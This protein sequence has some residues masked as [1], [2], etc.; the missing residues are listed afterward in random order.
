MKKK[1]LQPPKNGRIEFT[2]PIQ[3]NDWNVGKNIDSTCIKKLAYHP[4]DE[5][6]KIVYETA[7]NDLQ[8]YTYHDVPIEVAQKV[9][10]STRARSQ[11]GPPRKHSLGA[12][13]VRE[14]LDEG[15]HYTRKYIKFT[16]KDK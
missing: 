14:V 15:Y 2:K 11:Q 5:K 9:L 7:I 16:K 6:L 10:D 8:E 13:L 4:K 3:N 12:S 1:E